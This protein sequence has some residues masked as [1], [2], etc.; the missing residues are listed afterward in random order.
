LGIRFVFNRMFDTHCHL[1]TDAFDEDRQETLAAARAEGVARFL[2]PAIDRASFDATLNISA[3]E[4]DVYCALG[5]H[6]HSASEWS[7]EVGEEI[8]RQLA[9]HP[10]IVAIG[11]IG[12]D[13]YYD[14]APREAQI[15]AFEAQ[16][17]LAQ[18][19]R[20]PIIV[21]TRD[22]DE[23]VWRVLSSAYAGLDRSIPR[24]QLHC[25]SGT[26]ESMN[27]AVNEGFYI[28]FTGNITFKK[29]SLGEVV[30]ATPLDRI[31]LET[32]SPYLA[33]APLRG[34]RNTPANLRLVA[35]KIAELKNID[36]HEV[37]HQTT[38]N[39]LRLFTKVLP[40][41]LIL[42]MA[43][44]SA[45]AQRTDPIGSAPPDSVLTNER[46]KAEELRKRQDEEL[47]KEAEQRRQDSILSVQREFDELQ[48]KMTEQA[49]ED[50]ILAAERIADEERERLRMMTPVPWKAVGVG[51]GVGIANIGMILQKPS[52]T[53]TSVFA[54]TFELTSQVLRRL[55]VQLGF[56]H[57]HIGDEFLHDSVWNLG[58]GT[59][60]ATD[61]RKTG[62][63]PD[64]RLISG[65]DFDATVISFDARYVITRPSAAVS[66][67]LGAGYSHLSMSNEQRYYPRAD[68]FSFASQLKT[69]SASFS[70]GAMSLLFGMR[71]D[72][73]VGGGFT[74]TPYAQI[75]ALGAFQGTPGD[76]SSTQNRAFVFRADPDQIIMTHVK[77][78]VTI[79]YGWWGV[80]RVQ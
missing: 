33:P 1:Q 44:A 56:T 55:D 52:L 6:P 67:Y 11:E 13:Y 24:G 25:F 9:V 66:F 36:I 74:V 61:L 48:R 80:P 32:D 53:P 29:S 19:H 17:A 3:S 78:G 64:Q 60:T 58:P 47:Q 69:F 10:K 4:S 71:H 42:L 63:S 27:R 2:V 50:S 35:A 45:S 76:P 20:L 51:G 26:T 22:S 49:R 12:L 39:A 8:E 68:S 30:Q 40:V 21:H 18:K 15:R 73:E 41:C 72:F 75:S 37:M 57:L 70:R 14:F 31:L 54:S 43:A 65:E 28:S 5:I 77:V 16:I 79:A 38:T 23:D 46:R 34:K 59:P 7:S 62:Y